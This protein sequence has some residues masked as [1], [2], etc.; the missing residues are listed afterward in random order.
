MCNLGLMETWCGGGCEGRA[1]LRCGGAWAVG[2][3]IRDPEA[4]LSMGVQ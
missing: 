4:G 3:P 2:D 1:P